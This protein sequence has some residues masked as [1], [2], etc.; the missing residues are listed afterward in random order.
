[1]APFLYSQIGF[2]M[3]MG[4]LFFGQLPDSTSLIGMVVVTLSGLTGVWLGIREK[5]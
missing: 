5:R 4:W 1:M 2:A 3:L